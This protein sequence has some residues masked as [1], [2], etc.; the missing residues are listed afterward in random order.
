MYK[1]QALDGALGV[2][3]LGVGGG[4]GGERRAE[5]GAGEEDCISHLENLGNW[6]VVGRVQRYAG[7]VGASMRGWGRARGA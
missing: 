4:D 1:R 5:Q 3:D 6:I 2:R 7:G